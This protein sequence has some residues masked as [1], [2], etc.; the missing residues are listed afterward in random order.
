MPS[1]SGWSLASWAA[2]IIGRDEF[3]VLQAEIATANDPKITVITASFGAVR[4][5]VVMVMVLVLP[6]CASGSWAPG[7]FTTNTLFGSV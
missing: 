3:A 1:G 7:V 4:R 5:P 6:R 2:D